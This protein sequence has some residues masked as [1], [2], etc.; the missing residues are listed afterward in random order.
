MADFGEPSASLWSSQAT[1]RA[2]EHN[3]TT[4]G[5]FGVSI[6]IILYNRPRWLVPPALR[7]EPGVFQQGTP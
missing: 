7:S 2:A 4:L 5:T 1:P 3:A 6:A